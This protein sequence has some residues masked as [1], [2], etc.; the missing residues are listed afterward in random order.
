[1]N[2]TFAIIFAVIIGLVLVAFII[3]VEG[4]KKGRLKNFLDKYEG[5]MLLYGCP[6]VAVLLIGAAIYFGSNL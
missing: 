1:M 2:I 4:N 5:H 6:V 3:G